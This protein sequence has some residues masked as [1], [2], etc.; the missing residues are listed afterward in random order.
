[1]GRDKTIYNLIKGLIKATDIVVDT[2]CGNG[3]GTV[4][5]SSVA[6]KVV[7]IDRDKEKIL[8]AMRDNKKD[9]NYYVHDN[10]DQMEAFPICDVVVAINITDS[11]RFPLSFMGKIQQA[12]KRMVIVINDYE[13]P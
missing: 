9:N 4:I 6:K 3:D 1:M 12:A 8:S 10:L 2:G 13:K 7:G 11:L 5:L